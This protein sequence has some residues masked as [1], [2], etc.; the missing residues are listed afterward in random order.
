[1]TSTQKCIG[2]PP[3]M[4][5]CSVSQRALEHARTVPFRGAYLDLIELYDYLIKKDFQYPSTP[6][7]SHMFALDLQLDY[8]LNVEGLEKRYARHREMAEITRAWAKENFAVF[9]QPGYESVTLTTI[10]NT[11]GISISDLNKRL[12]EAGYQISNGYGEL[13][14][15]TFRIAHMAERTVDEL[16]TLLNLI[17]TITAKM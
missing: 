16:R 1:I 7:L 11:R 2:L 5:I 15:K 10:T 14:E 3:G 6:S 17:D 8:I 4:A 13:K 12:G 9:P